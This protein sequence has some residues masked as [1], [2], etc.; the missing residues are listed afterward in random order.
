[1][2]T[3]TSTRRTFLRQA[4]GASAVVLAGHM[5]GA[6]ATAARAASTGPLTAAQTATLASWCDTVVPGAASADVGAF[7]GAQLAKPA[8]DALLMLRYLDWPPPFA[9]FYED[10]I[11]AVD[12]L[13]ADT[14]GTRFEALSGSRRESLVARVVAGDAAWSG[15]PAYLFYLATRADAVDVVYGTPEGHRRVGAPTRLLARPPAR[16]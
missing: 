10:G 1:M 6:S 2:F 14:Y 5:I 9:P 7:V 12:R 15:P 16:W 3:Q 4:G 11:A 13:S 8:E